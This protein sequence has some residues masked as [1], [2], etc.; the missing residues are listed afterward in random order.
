MKVIINFFEFLSWLFIGILVILVFF[1]L[2]SNTSILG[3]YKSFLV[4]SGSMEPT[5]MTGDIIIIHQNDQY[6]KN[7][8]VT[9]QNLENRIVTHRIAEIAEKRGRTSFITKGDANRSK[10]EDTIS[11]SNV[12]GKVVFIVPRF[13]FLVAFAK[14]LPGLIVLIGIPALALIMNELLKMSK[15]E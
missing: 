14:S 13:G 6:I 12:L 15:D 9:F 2:G 3:G 11:P 7:D 10:D 4:Q 1:T 8:V 5:I